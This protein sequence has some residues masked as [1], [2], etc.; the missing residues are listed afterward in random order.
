[1]ARVD[2]ESLADGRWP[3][4]LV[5]AGVNASYFKTTHGP[6]PFCSDGGSDRYRWSS[7]H[8]G[9]YVCS[10]CTNGAYRNGFDFLARHMGYRSFAEAA[11]HVRA[12]FGVTDGMSELAVVQ[13]MAKLPQKV[14]ATND[15]VKAIARM[16]RQWE[17]SQAVTPGDPVHQYLMNRVPGLKVVPSEIRLHPNLA[18]WSPPTTPQGSPILVGKF[19]AMLLRGLDADGNF[20]QLHK[21]YLDEHGHK[22][23][24][25]CPKKTDQ[26]VGCSSFALRIGV[27]SDTLGVDEGVETGLAAM[28][29]RDIPVWPCHCSSVLANFEVP[30]IYASRVRKLIIF[31]DSD[32]R[33]N[34]HKAGEEAAW[35]LSDRMRKQGRKVLIMRPAKVGW[36]F[37]N[38]I[39]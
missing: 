28:I 11:D 31:A 39:C 33:K 8:G 27:P 22:A 25:P 29:L 7:K 4:I 5:A 1:M 37:A 9:V 13:R 21:T 26:G 38:L 10:Q 32:V 6:C 12:Y 3:D 14:I 15:P 18:Y 35:R 30:A 16:S 23:D 36:D 19:P 24:V 17:E 20:V 2:A 34:G